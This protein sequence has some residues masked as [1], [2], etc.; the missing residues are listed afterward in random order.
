MHFIFSNEVDLS[1]VRSV[2]ILRKKTTHVEIL[3]WPYF[4]IP[5][6]DIVHSQICFKY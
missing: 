3:K 6:H 1:Q 2:V 5:Q 4:L